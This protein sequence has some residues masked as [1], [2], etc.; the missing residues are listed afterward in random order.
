MTHK[1][2]AARFDATRL[3]RGT[4]AAAAI[5]MLL[6][7]LAGL[8][9]WSKSGGLFRALM[10]GTL[11]SKVIWLTAA[12][13]GLYVLLL[14][15]AFFLGVKRFFRRHGFF[16]PGCDKTFLGLHFRHIL[17]GGHCCF[18]GERVLHEDPPQ[19]AK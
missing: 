1:E 12:L 18:C 16:C 13:S 10:G 8:F 3:T 19:S 2:F 5:L 6:A 7:P 15:L 9:Y 17:S 4:L 14:L 11:N